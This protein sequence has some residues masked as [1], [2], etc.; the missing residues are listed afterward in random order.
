MNKSRKYTSKS[1]LLSRIYIGLFIFTMVMFLWFERHQFMI[2]LVFVLIHI[3]L[4][5]APYLMESYYHILEGQI[6]KR[7]NNITKRATY[8]KMPH[9]FIIPIEPIDIIEYKKKQGSVATLRFK[10]HKDH[11]PLG[12]ITIEDAEEFI[13]EL[14]LQN[15]RFELKR[16]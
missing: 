11:I 16:I 4:A 14:R 8:E 1:N 2:G 6:V 7:D 5:A 3:P 15:D 10:S 9:A 13:T 12:I